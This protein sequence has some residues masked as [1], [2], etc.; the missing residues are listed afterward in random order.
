MKKEFTTCPTSL[1]D[2][3]TYGFSWMDFVT[4]IPSPLFL[5]TSYKE[6]G[7]ANAC[8]QSWASFVGDN[9]GFYCIL[10]AV[11]TAGHLYQTLKQRGD[12]VINFMSGEYYGRCSQTIAHNGYGQ[13]ELAA[14]GLTAKPSVLVNAPRVDE[15]FLN[16]ECRYAWEHPLSP[17]GTHATVCLSVHH[18]AME[19]AYLDETLQGRYGP[20]GYLY[21]IHRPV[22]PL[23]RGV[24]G[25]ALAVLTK[26]RDEYTY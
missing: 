21:N 23:H 25:D 5:V 8:L 22:N 19:E 14:A 7:L 24:E 12:A 26:L 17:A 16:L 18:V 6:N 15:C 3:E 1:A 10:A 13:D 4:A 2:M 20:S 9:D 11:N